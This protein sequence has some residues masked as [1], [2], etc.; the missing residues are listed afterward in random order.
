MRNGLKTIV[1]IA[2]GATVTAVGRAQKQCSPPCECSV[3]PA[4]SKWGYAPRG[5]R[6]EG[7]Y[8]VPIS[9]GRQQLLRLASFTLGR[10]SLDGN[11]ASH[12]KFAWR[13]ATDEL[14][15]V[16][17]PRTHGVYYRMD[18]TLP[19]NS[20]GFSWGLDV[21]QAAHVSLDDLGFLLKDRRDV[22][23]PVAGTTSSLLAS[24]ADYF[25]VVAP[26]ILVKNL[27]AQVRDATGQ[28]V[29]TPLVPHRSFA[30]E[31]GVTFTIPA[32]HAQGLFSLHLEAKCLEGCAGNDAPVV[33]NYSFQ[34]P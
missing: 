30:G 22:Y 25:F 5:D 4:Q 24:Q 8:D 3:V 28:I 12:L 14:K 6:C 31:H 11:R 17:A 7:M 34:I 13:S 23:R 9:M 19:S 27:I 29:D 10:V 2:L 18:T 1:L 32:S 26:R 33:S 16:A 21:L 15:L 20:H